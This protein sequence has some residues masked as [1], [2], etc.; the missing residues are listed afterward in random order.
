M[1]TIYAMTKGTFYY[2][3]L[4]ARDQKRGGAGLFGRA[5]AT[6]SEER[7]RSPPPPRVGRRTVE[8]SREE[9]E[10]GRD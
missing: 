5:I 6:V 4:G 2:P 10:K 7:E 3:N 1:R 9:P 8:S